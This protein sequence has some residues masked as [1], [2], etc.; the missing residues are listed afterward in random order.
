MWGGAMRCQ[1]ATCVL[2]ERLARV[3]LFDRNEN[4]GLGVRGEKLGTVRSVHAATKGSAFSGCMTA[5]WDRVGSPQFFAGFA[6]FRGA[7][8]VADGPQFSRTSTIL[9]PR[10]DAVRICSCERPHDRT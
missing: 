5:P 4:A 2:V 3:F 8:A 1:A 7:C 10:W 6:V 9:R